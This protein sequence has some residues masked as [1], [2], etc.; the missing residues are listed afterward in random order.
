MKFL[1]NTQFQK[2]KTLKT[3]QKFSVIHY[4]TYLRYG[5]NVAK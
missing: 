3:N 2:L 5:K 4:L 1:I